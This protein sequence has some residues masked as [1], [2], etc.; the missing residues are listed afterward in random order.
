MSVSPVLKITIL[1]ENLVRRRNLLA[2]HGL[3]LWI[4]DDADKV[5]FDSGQTGVYLHNAK[6]LNID[7]TE[8]HA[9]VLSHGHYDHGGGLAYFL[10]EARWP[11]VFVHPDALLSKF[12]KVKDSSEQYKAIGVPWKI[13]DLDHLEK[14]LMFNTS[15]MQIGENMFICSG[16]PQTTE[17]ELPSA[18]LMV[19]KGDQMVVDDLHDEQ[20]LVCQREQG[21][22]VVLGCSH[23][24]IVN[25]LKFVQQLLPGKTI[26][27]IIG[28]MHLENVNEDR[29]RQ[30]IMFLSQLNAN[31]VPLH[32]TGQNVIWRMKQELGERVLICCTGDEIKLD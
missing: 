8:A 15:T 24:G 23:P 9:V 12:E 25:C 3:S 1:T 28:G 32:C 20:I 26:Q 22:I 21:I 10:K 17:F 4:E 14:H 7:L 19:K 11:R 2:E 5:L 31:I 30:T 13:G 18:K 6:E 29:L 16:I 27:T